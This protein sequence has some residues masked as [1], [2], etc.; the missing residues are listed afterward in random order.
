MGKLKHTGDSDEEIPEGLLT[1]VSSDKEDDDRKV[2]KMK[3]RARTAN[4]VILAQI[5]K[6]RDKKKRRK[7]NKL[8]DVDPADR[9]IPIPIIKPPTEFE[10]LLAAINPNKNDKV[11]ESE[12]QLEIL[13]MQDRAALRDRGL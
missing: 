11:K 3:K 2:L 6:L 4:T 9:G 13:K 5:D 8:T 12:F 1:T 7:A 10:M